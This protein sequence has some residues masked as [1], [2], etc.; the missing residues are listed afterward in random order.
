MLITTPT[1]EFLARALDMSALRQA[2]HST[3]IANASVPGFRRLEVRFDQALE[4][5]MLAAAQGSSG[6]D[7]SAATTNAAVVS[8]DSQV[9]LD[10][11]VAAMARNTLRYQTLLTALQRG[12]TLLRM[13]VREG[14]E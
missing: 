6:R 13:A 12:S 11:E 8:T 7:I 1:T 10:E 3:N 4:R 5:V 14:R 2:V 9:K